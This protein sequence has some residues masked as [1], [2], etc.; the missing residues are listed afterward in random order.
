MDK[1]FIGMAKNN[2]NFHAYCYA[3][4]SVHDHKLAKKAAKEL[5]GFIVR[6]PSNFY[7][8]SKGRIYFDRYA[9]CH[10]MDFD[11]DGLHDPGYRLVNMHY[12]SNLDTVWVEIEDWYW[13]TSNKR[14]N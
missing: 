9:T 5:T 2:I 7:I 14:Y 8:D 12:V 10:N 13:P 6:N 1:N 3:T 11:A 4:K